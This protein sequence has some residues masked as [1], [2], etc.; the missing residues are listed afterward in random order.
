MIWRISSWMIL[1]AFD[2]FVFDQVEMF[3]VEAHETLRIS[4]KCSACRGVPSTVPHQTRRGGGRARQ[5]M[6][7]PPVLFTETT[8]PPSTYTALSSVQML[9]EMPKGPCQAWQNW[10]L[11][12]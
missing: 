12:S 7:L 11:K 9:C 6:L 1:G 10:P 3:V 5:T 8:S 2:S 4:G